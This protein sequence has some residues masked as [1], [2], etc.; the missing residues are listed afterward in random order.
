M[1]SPSQCFID[2]AVLDVIAAMGPDQR[3]RRPSN[4]M[5]IQ[6]LNIDA[7][8][9]ALLIFF[10]NSGIPSRLTSLLVRLAGLLTQLI[11]GVVVVGTSSTSSVLTAILAVL[12][13]IF[14]IVEGLMSLLCLQI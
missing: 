1:L 14:G 11:A 6:I 9:L 12:V 2:L 8:V 4:F 5:I 7:R 10:R 13:F 3:N